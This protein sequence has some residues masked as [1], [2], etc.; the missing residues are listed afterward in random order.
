MITTILKIAHLSHQLF[1]TGELLLKTRDEDTIK[2]TK[3]HCKTTTNK[4]YLSL[5]GN[6]FIVLGLN[7]EKTILY[8][9]V[10]AF[11]I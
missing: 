9:Q 11:T 7:Q 2:K 5:A 8:H 4:T 3:V 6:L 10:L 1:V